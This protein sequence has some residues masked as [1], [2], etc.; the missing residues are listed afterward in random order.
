MKPTPFLHRRLRRPPSSRLRLR[1]RQQPQW[2]AFRHHC[3]RVMDT[4][5]TPSSLPSFAT[6]YNGP[7][8]TSIRLSTPVTRSDVTVRPHS[9][10]TTST[11]PSS[12]RSVAGSRIRSRAGC[13]PST[14][15]GSHSE[16]L[17]ESRR[18]TPHLIPVRPK[19][20]V[21]T[22][23]F[24]YDAC[25]VQYLRAV[26]QLV[27]RDFCAQ[28]AGAASP[29]FH[30]DGPVCYCHCCRPDP[31]TCVGCDASSVEASTTRH[32]RRQHTTPLE[33]ILQP[34]PHATGFDVVLKAV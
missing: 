4:R 30:L 7:A 13:C 11:T 9:D 34:H 8:A 29:P 6:C 25:P 28:Q 16:C 31:V 15:V 3:K 27:P 22:P 23:L 18:A 33:C 17:R 21:R 14:S 2:A 32:H 1:L 26:P 19:T 12:S 5:L 20:T 24:L 10:S